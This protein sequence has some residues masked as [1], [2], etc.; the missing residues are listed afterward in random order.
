[1]SPSERKSKVYSGR[2]QEIRRPVPGDSFR[3]QVTHWLQVSLSV[4]EEEADVGELFSELQ[5]GSSVLGI[6]CFQGWVAS[7][8]RG[9]KF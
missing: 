1:M 7:E 3:G 2:K 6:L 9:V 4:K 8:L 5:L